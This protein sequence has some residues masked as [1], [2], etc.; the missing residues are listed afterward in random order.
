VYR[1]PALKRVFTN[2]MKAHKLTALVYPATPLP[3]ALAKGADNTQVE[4]NGLVVDAAS[5]YSRN[6]RAASAAGLPALTVPCGMTKPHPGAPK[7]SPG[8]ERLPVALEFIAAPNDDE[9]LL[10]VG[11]AFQRLQSL[12]PDPIIMRRWGGGVTYPHMG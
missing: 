7:G 6:T 5:I 1:R 2:V 10:S 11:R 3:A 9:K 12:L 4:H 8:A